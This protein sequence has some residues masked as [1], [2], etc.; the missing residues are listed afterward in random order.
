[1]VDIQSELSLINQFICI[2]KNMHLVNSVVEI[3]AQEGSTLNYSVIQKGNLSSNL[4][5]S[6]AVSQSSNSKINYKMKFNNPFNK[7]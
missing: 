7:L 6:T 2:D 1:M 4:I 3:E 5:E